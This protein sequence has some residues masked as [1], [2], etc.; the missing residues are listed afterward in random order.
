MKKQPKP[1]DLFKVLHDMSKDDYKIFFDAWG[2]FKPN[3]FIKIGFPE[4]YVAQF[5]RTHHSDGSYKGSI[6]VDGKVI[7]KLVAVQC[8]DI[9]INLAHAF[10]L[11]KALDHHFDMMGRGFALRALSTPIWE[12][13]RDINNL[14]KLKEENNDK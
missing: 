10:K 7:D 11:E 1:E 14:E 6:Y 4:D 3:A 8:V 2:L 12:F 9:A 5:L 13:T